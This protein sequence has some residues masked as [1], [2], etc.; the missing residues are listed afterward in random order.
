MEVVVHACNL[1]TEAEVGRLSLVRGQ[2]ELQR[3]FLS[4]KKGVGK[5]DEETGL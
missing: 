3:L 5:Q 1:S 2:P 4:G